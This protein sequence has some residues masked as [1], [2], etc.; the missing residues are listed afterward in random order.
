MHAELPAQV[1]AHPRD[2]AQHV[3]HPVLLTEKDE[4]HQAAVLRSELPRH[5]LDHTEHDCGKVQLFLKAVENL[6]QKKLLFGQT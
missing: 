1:R 5:L 2:A 6:E 4:P 3:G